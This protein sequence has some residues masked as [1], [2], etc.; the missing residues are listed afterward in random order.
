MYN[1]RNEYSTVLMVLRTAATLAA[2]KRSDAKSAHRNQ[3]AGIWQ[4]VTDFLNSRF[5]NS[6]ISIVPH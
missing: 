2:T 3:E 6:S 1:D 4:D 5:E